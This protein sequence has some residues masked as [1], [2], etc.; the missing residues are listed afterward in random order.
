MRHSAATGAQLV[1]HL[2]GRKVFVV[3]RS[4]A[5]GTPVPESVRCGQLEDSAVRFT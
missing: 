1:Q 4:D 3:E 2:L 5:S